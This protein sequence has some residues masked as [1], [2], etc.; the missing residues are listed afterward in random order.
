MEK[1]IKKETGG[2]KKSANMFIKVVMLVWTFLIIQQQQKENEVY[3]APS[4][5]NQLLIPRNAPTLL[6]C[7]SE[8]SSEYSVYHFNPKN[9]SF[10]SPIG[11]PF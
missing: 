6:D 5:F 3:F 9:V 7:N 2:A 1:K 4:N 11:L 8:D 10:I